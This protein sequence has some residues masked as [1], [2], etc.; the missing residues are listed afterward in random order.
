LPNK[1]TYLIDTSRRD[2][3]IGGSHRTRIRNSLTVKQYLHPLMMT[4]EVFFDA[5]SARVRTLTFTQHIQNSRGL[6]SP[7]LRK[8]KKSRKKQKNNQKN[9]DMNMHA[10][11]YLALFSQHVRTREILAD[12]VHIH[13]QRFRSHSTKRELRSYDRGDASRCNC[14]S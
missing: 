6:L 14:R 12:L 11:L 13:Y 8:V 5:L 7:F 2:E 4:Q 1:R 10:K 3:H 9:R